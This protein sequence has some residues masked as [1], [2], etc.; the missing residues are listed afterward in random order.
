MSAAVG[1]QAESAAATRATRAGTWQGQRM[2]P[3]G[4]GWDLLVRGTRASTG[5][6]GAGGSH[7]AGCRRWP[8]RNAQ[9]RASRGRTPPRASK[10]F[11]TPDASGSLRA[12]AL[13]E[14]GLSQAAF[15]RAIGVSP[16][17]ISHVVK[18]NLQSDHDL[19]VAGTKIGPRLRAIHSVTHAQV[20]AA[21]TEATRPAPHSP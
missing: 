12:E 14:L 6:R 19:K 11:N 9:N 2:G 21:R 20:A 3:P 5:T 8:G 7:P 10:A 1:A 4:G 18:L 13:G 17:R 15:A 16:M